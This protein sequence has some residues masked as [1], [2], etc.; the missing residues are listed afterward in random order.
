MKLWG[1]CNSAADLMDTAA[2]KKRPIPEEI[3]KESAGLGYL[4]RYWSFF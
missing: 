4:F 3:S 2:S 1:S